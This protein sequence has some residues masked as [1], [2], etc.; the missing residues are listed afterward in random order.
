NFYEDENFDESRNACVV[1]SRVTNPVLAMLRQ[2]KGT[3][4]GLNLENGG[5]SIDGITDSAT[6]SVNG[7]VTPGKTVTVTGKKIRVVPEEG[8]TVES[9]ITW[10]NVETQ[11]V[12]EQ[13]D[14][15]TVN[16]PSRIILQLPALTPGTYSLII[17]TLFSSG[18]INLKAPRYIT[19]NIRLEVK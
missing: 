13:E 9:C 8:E 6:G 3:F 18:S 16:D 4:N 17:K 1:N 14:A 12:V 19:S 11:Q 2:V 15:L 5:A 7:E 10:T